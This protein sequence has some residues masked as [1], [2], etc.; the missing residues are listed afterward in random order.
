MDPAQ[1]FLNEVTLQHKAASCGINV[2]TPVRRAY[3]GKVVFVT[4]GNGFLGKHLLEKLFRSCNIKMAYLLMRPKKGKSVWERLEELA[5][6]VVFEGLRESDPDFVDKLVPVE[7]DIKELRL[8]MSDQDWRIVTDETEVI[9]HAAATINFEEPLREATLTNVRGTREVV[10][11]ARDCWKLRALVHISTAYCHATRD[12]IGKDVLDQFYPAPVDPETLIDLAETMDERL[13]ISITPQLLQKW[14]NTYTFTKA[15]AEEVIRKAV[16]LPIAVVRP[17]IVICAYREP[18]PG[19][20]DPSGVYGPSGLVLGGGLGLLHVL[21]ASRTAVIDLV[22]VDYVNNAIIAAGWAVME[23]VDDGVKIYTVATTRHP[24]LWGDTHNVLYKEV[25]SKYMTPKSVWFACMVDVENKWLYLTLAFF[26][27]FVPGYVLDGV[28]CCMLKPP[29]F[30]KLYTKAAKLQRVLSYFTCNDWR[31]GDE[32]TVTLFR[33]MS[34]EDQ[35]LYNFDI[36]SV[37]WKQQIILWAIGVQKSAAMDPALAREVALLSRRRVIDEAIERGDSE[38][39]QFYKDATVLVSGG[40]GF[41]GKQ[42]LEKLFRSC[43]IKKVFLLMRPKKKKSFNERLS[44]IL[45]DPVFDAVKKMKPGFEAKIQPILGDASQP[46]LGISDEDYATI[47]AETEI[48][49]HGA[50]TIN[51]NE[52]LRVAINTNVGG[53]VEMLKI[54]KQCRK[55]KSYV[56]ISTAFAQATESRVDNDVLEQ[57]YEAPLSPNV[58]IEMVATMD[59]QKIN[60]ITPHLIKNWPNTYTFTKAIAEEACRQ[61]GSEL[62]ISIFRPA[63]VVASILEPAPGWVDISC[64]YGPSGFLVG[65]GLGVMHTMHVDL[66]RIIDLVPVD[67]VNNAII[68]TAAV[69]AKR[70]SEGDSETKIY[71][72]TSMRNSITWRRIFDIMMKDFQPTIVTPMAPYY[73]FSIQTSNSFIY[74]ILSWLW[75]FIPA[76]IIDGIMYCMGKTPMA[77]KLYTKMTTHTKV[78]SFFMTNS[79][80]MKDNKL[81]Q[82]YSSLSSTDKIIFNCDV[83]TLNWKDL[84]MA[85]T[86]GC[87]KY[88]VKDGLQGTEYAIKKQFWLKLLH[89]FVVCPIYFFLL[90]KVASLAFRILYFFLSIILSIFV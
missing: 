33:K 28:R 59:E 62:P 87:R 35:I 72:F 80:N 38:V 13:L 71:T 74:F 44:Y 63:I 31:F 26:F 24:I 29:F 65:S 34:K 4:G 18:A 78:L 11:L 51:F 46:R 14:P 67:L 85:W 5:K 40:T 55:L 6:D 68:A 17:A 16:G 37:N 86:L 83:A 22:P 84:L 58:A 41:I 79:W 21:N 20:L 45:E 70:R 36:A 7:G 90:Y 50:A 60:D 2:N 12:R 49:F 19:W 27:H 73:I 54:G 23:R 39:Q 53:T 88:V 66:D 32:N 8:G 42:M 10:E 57:F 77:V 43:E 9:F 3:E 82:L 48:I 76:Y 69:T 30:I 47:I 61:A 75:H 81:Q 52:P 56:H 25:A 64:V 15:V 89:Y 1:E